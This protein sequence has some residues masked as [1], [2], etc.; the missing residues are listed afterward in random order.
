MNHLQAL[1]PMIEKALGDA[2]ISKKELE[3]IAVSTGPGLIYRHKN[4]N[5]CGKNDGAGPGPAD[6]GCADA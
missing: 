4:R 3:L 6:G 1:F 5:G 2:G